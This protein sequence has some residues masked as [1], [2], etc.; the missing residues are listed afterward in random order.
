LEMEWEKWT[1]LFRPPDAENKIEYPALILVLLLTY[2]CSESIKYLSL[3]SVS[4][5]SQVTELKAR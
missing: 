4:V 5:R 1:P 3:V 2:F